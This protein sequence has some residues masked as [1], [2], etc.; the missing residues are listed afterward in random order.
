M[1]DTRY[2][3]TFYRLTPYFPVRD[4]VLNLGAGKFLKHVL[5]TQQLSDQPHH[6]QGFL[7]LAFCNGGAGEVFE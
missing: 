4:L 3:T 7:R 1:S 5:S 2:K 6:G